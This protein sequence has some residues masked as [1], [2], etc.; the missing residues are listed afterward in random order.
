MMDTR[1]DIGLGV[2]PQEIVM[3]INENITNWNV[4]EIVT[5]YLVNFEEISQN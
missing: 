1:V 5:N 3:K 4:M 2:D